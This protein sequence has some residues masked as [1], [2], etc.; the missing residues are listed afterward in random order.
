MIIDFHTHAFSEKIAART[1]EALKANGE[2]VS[3]YPMHACTDGTAPSLI[4]VERHA[5]ADMAV[6]LPIVTKPSQTETVNRVARETN[7]AGGFLHSFGSVHPLDGD[8]PAWLD[9]LAGEGFRGIK[10]HPEFQGYYA[11]CPEA[12]AV[13]ARAEKLGLVVVL[14]AGCDIGYEPPVKTTPEMLRRVIDKHPDLKL[15]AAHLGGWKM[16]DDVSKYLVGTP[17]YLDTAFISDFIDKSVCRDIICA[18][19]AQRVLFGSDAPWEDPAVTLDFI[20]SLGLDLN[21]QRMICGENAAKLIGV[22]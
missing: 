12:M 21:A 13:Y 8:A 16:W 3:H 14:H 20:R 5:G 6:L 9:R 11:D 1:V 7:E 17:V 18:H 19:G 2:R 4:E 15:V 10:L 22:L